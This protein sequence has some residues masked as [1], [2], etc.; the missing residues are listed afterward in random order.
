MFVNLL[1]SYLFRPG[2]YNGCCSQS[3]SRNGREMEYVLASQ[4]VQ[5]SA[6]GAGV[7]KSLQHTV[8]LLFTHVKN[9]SAVGE[10][11]PVTI[12]LKAMS[13]KLHF[14]SSIYFKQTGQLSI[15][16]RFKFESQSLEW[17]KA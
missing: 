12:Q 10:F 16:D 3:V 4:Q 17:I 8:T 11:Q 7:D 2:T 13:S 15:R 5:L 6:S 1:F 9:Y 14:T